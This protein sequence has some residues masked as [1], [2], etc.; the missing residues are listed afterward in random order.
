MK[1]K[2][3]HARS[4]LNGVERMSGYDQTNA[5]KRAGDKLSNWRP[6][7]LA[8][9]ERFA[10]GCEFDRS[11]KSSRRGIHSHT[12]TNRAK[13]KQNAHACLRQPHNAVTESLE[14]ITVYRMHEL[15]VR[16]AV[17]RRDEADPTRCTTTRENDKS[18]RETHAA[19]EGIEEQQHREREEG[20]VRVLM[21]PSS[22]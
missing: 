10:Y 13:H 15:S 18:A 20:P 19:K 5:G 21:S 16:E 7:T 3:Y 8:P 14:L 6:Y 4:Y 22:L 2:G 1:D 9:E 12:R 17:D 11:I